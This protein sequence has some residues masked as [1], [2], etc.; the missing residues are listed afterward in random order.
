MVA[1]GILAVLSATTGLL[2]IPEVLGGH[3]LLHHYLTSVIAET[4]PIQHDHGL[5]LTLM[6]ISTF[7]MVIA[8][9]LAY[10]LY[11]TG[12]SPVTQALAQGLRPFYLLS[13]HKY[14][15]D[16]LFVLLFVR[17][18]KNMSLF[19]HRVID[20]KAIDGIVNGLGQ[21]TLFVAAATSYKMSGSV[22]RHAMFFVL[23]L[24]GVTALLLW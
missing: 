18:A 20:V 21:V 10:R 5:E 8:S 15:L 16:E 3:N 4:S 1:S 23:G 22:H 12:Y 24:A 2:G 13:L 11:R 7:A 17:P 9:L 19:V 14:W 6:G